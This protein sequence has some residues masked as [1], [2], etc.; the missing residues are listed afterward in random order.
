MRGLT[1]TATGAWRRRATIGAV[2]ALCALFALLSAHR[3]AGAA[4]GSSGCT[5]TCVIL[6][7]VDGLEPKDVTPQTTPFLWKLA[8][9]QPA[10]SSP[11]GP[12]ASRSGF[13]WQAPRGVVSTGT[14]PAT[15]SLLTGAYPELSGVPSDEFIDRGATGDAR[16][17]LGAGGFGD[18]D[19]AK[20]PEHSPVT[21]AGP[22]SSSQVDTLIEAVDGANGPAASAVFLGDPAL[23]KLAHASSSETQSFWYPPGDSRGNNTSDAPDQS[24]GDPRLCPIPRYPGDTVPTSPGSAQPNPSACPADDATV[25]SKAATDLTSGPAIASVGFTFIELAE[26]GVAKRAAG[27]SDLAPNNAPP[28]PPQALADTDAAIAAFAGQYAQQAGPKWANTVLMVVGSHGYE[29]TPIAKRVPDPRPSAGAT[30]DLSDFVSEYAPPGGS[31]GDLTLVPQGTMATIYYW[32]KDGSPLV[33]AKRAAALESIKNAL[34]PLDGSPGD[35]NTKCAQIDPQPPGA[36]PPKKGGACIREVDYLDSGTPGT[37]DTVAGQHPS[38]HLDALDP[39]DPSAHVR[40][41]ASGDLVVLLQPGWATGRAAGTSGTPSQAQ[42]DDQAWSNPYTASSGGPRERAV[43]ALVNGPKA[44]SN[45]GAVR[46]L[47]TFDANVNYYPV[48]KTPADPS[49]PRPIPAGDQ[50]CPA[51]STDP[52]KVA[53]VDGLACANNPENVGDDA[54]STGHEAQPVTVDFA[55]TVSA[56]MGVPF[57]QHPEQLQGRVLQEAFLNKLTAP[58]TSGCEPPPPPICQDVGAVTQRDQIVPLNLSCTDSNGDALTYQIASGPAHGTLGPVENAT[59]TYTP[60]AGF[61]GTDSFTYQSTSTNGTSALATASI[62]VVEP[63]QVSRPR[64]F[65]FTGLVRRLTA[66]VVDGGNHPYSQA[67]R[68]AV[69]STIRLEGDFGKPEAAL[70]LTF[71]RA[72]GARASSARRRAAR[73]TLKAIARFDPFIVKRGHVTIRLKVPPLFSPTY[74]GVTVREVVRGRSA[75]AGATEACTTLK[76]LRPLHFRCAGP[77]QGLIVP[78]ADASRLHRRKGSAR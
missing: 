34:L 75:R 25:M 20:D 36:A 22:V 70:S 32:P 49:D 35:V 27:G 47:D 13:I 55:L 28:S 57:D 77:S 37:S 6:I 9:P 14:A 38:W 66:R 21:D 7:Q 78:I 73:K 50:A 30:S 33:P 74:L 29:A 23:A 59:V 5:P 52:N 44:G 19:L 63:P 53:D 60:A 11:V 69:L 39:K 42:L 72:V 15:A 46:N 58:C 65:D 12:L 41:G 31:Q 67:K 16:Q 45:P 51:T 3:E 1:G 71:Y 61:T 68:G 17:R 24:R 10:D 4:T 43:A 26:L 54:G 18:Q 48:S 62:I 64:G 8:H 76:T 2:A 56:L 40:T